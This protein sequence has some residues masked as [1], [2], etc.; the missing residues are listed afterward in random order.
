[1]D[2]CARRAATELL[3]F[4]WIHQV[5]NFRG[6]VKKLFS[7]MTK[8][9]RNPRKFTP[10]KIK[11]FMVYWHKDFLGSY[12]VCHYLLAITF[13]ICYTINLHNEKWKIPSTRIHSKSLDDSKSTWPGLISACMKNKTRLSVL[14]WLLSYQN[15]TVITSTGVFSMSL[16]VGCP[17][18]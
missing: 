4:S 6:F 17:C 14:E 18:K 5:K 12:V 2:H 3:K 1:M 8:W 16:V 7:R 10:T 15:C 9:P 13:C 11:T